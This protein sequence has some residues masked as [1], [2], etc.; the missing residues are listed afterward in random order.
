MENSEQK[1]VLTSAPDKDGEYFVSDMCQFVK[2]TV[3][4]RTV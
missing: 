4:R 3:S 1:Q 2:M